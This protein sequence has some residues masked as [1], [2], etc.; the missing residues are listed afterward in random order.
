MIV[1]NDHGEYIGGAQL[2][3]GPHDG[4]ISNGAAIG[5]PGA[6][7]GGPGHFFALQRR[8]H[9]IPLDFTQSS[10]QIASFLTDFTRFFIHITSFPLI[11]RTP[12]TPMETPTQRSSRKKME[13]D[14]DKDESNDTEEDD[15]DKEDEEE[16]TAFLTHF[17]NY[18]HIIYDVVP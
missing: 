9:L 5:H 14:H 15:S 6:N 2:K 1:I 16:E 3:T 8:T 4:S 11:R 12:T 18:S 7:F 10:I 17:L 13:N